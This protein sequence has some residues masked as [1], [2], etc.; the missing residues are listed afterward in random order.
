M[1]LLFTG[2]GGAGSE[3]IYR[4]LSDRYDIHFADA[5][6]NAIDQQIPVSHRHK[7]PMADS[8][9]FS[10]I[11]EELCVQLSIDLLIPTVD[12]E[13]LKLKELDVV[14]VMLPQTNYIET[15]LDKLHSIQLL[16][17]FNLDVPKT[18]LVDD[19]TETN[20][21]DFPCI[22]KPRN[23]RGSRNVYTIE[24]PEQISAYLKLTGLQRGEAILQKKIFGDEYT[25]LVSADQKANLHAIVPIKVGIKRGITI[26]AE[27][28]SNSIVEGACRVI[29]EKIPAQGC[30]NIQLMLTSSGK[31]F[32]FE[33]NPRI[34]T[35]FCM[36]LE[37]GIN[38]IEL[39]MQDRAPETLSIFQSGIKLS[40]YWRNIFS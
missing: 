13:L 30:Y 16:S 38:P 17:K 25:V 3:S 26:K 19:Y 8:P 1:R 9:D 7:I 37:A 23:G 20:C 11:V 10:L 40:R 15:M 35:T 34:S 36:S 28:E 27:T 14:D 32:P 39:Y 24:D 31:V 21:I 18:I 33:V 5:D 6:I 22:I 29:H 2:G 12:E 4:L